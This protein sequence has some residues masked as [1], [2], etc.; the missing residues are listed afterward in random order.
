MFFGKFLKG[1]LMYNLICLV[2]VVMVKVL[3]FLLL[4]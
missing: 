2:V 1:D 3:Y 4:G